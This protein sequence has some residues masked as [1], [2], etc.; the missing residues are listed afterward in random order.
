MG[1]IF[2]DPNLKRAWIN[3]SI[4]YVGDF[5][6]PLPSM[7]VTNCSNR[8]AASN[9]LL[10][11]M[12]FQSGFLI[13]YF[14]ET[15]LKTKAQEQSNKFGNLATIISKETDLTIKFIFQQTFNSYPGFEWALQYTTL[16][17][18]KMT[19]LLLWADTNFKDF[20]LK[21][22]LNGYEPQPEDSVKSLS[23]DDDDDDKTKTE[24][25]PSFLLLIIFSTIAITT[26]LIILKKINNVEIKNI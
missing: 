16:I 19:G 26:V 3:V 9:L 22:S 23:S 11:Y 13:P 17:Y 2:N 6:P 5:P 15:F 21:I 14:N 24:S 7:I 10:G 12:D 4:Y 1:D 20:K 18:E 25:I 8:E